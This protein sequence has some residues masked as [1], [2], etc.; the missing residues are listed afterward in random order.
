MSDCFFILLLL[1]VMFDSYLRGV[2]KNWIIPE[3][4]CMLIVR[5]FPPHLFSIRLVTF[6]GR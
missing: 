3:T 6:I 2:L 4:V 5:I 1:F